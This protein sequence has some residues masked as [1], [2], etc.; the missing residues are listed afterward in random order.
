MYR[1]L[2]LSLAVAS[3]TACGKS[4]GGAKTAV[5]EQAL[6]EAK[7][8]F[9]QRCATCH[10]PEGKG[11]GPAGAALNPKP[12]TFTDAEWQKKVDDDHLRKII[13]GGGPAVGLSPMMAPNPDLKDKPQVIDGLVQLV[14]GMGGK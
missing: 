14:R 12:R 8:I 11:D 1:S 9:A 5:S 6:A 3:L 7:T 10:G 13:V 2:L 4:D